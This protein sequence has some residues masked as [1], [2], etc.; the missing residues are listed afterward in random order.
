MIIDLQ[1]EPLRTRNL[2]ADVCIVGAGPAGISLALELARSRP[3][4]HIVL[5]EA[6]GPDNATDQEKANYRAE[7]GETS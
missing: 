7:L 2:T 4:W 3:D 5:A 1:H 6:G